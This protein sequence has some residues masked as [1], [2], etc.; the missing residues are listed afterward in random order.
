MLY[1]NEKEIYVAYISKYNS[2]CKKLIILLMIRNEK[3]WHYLR[4]TKLSALLRRITSK[5]N[6]DFCCLNCLHSFR[7]ENKLK[8]Y[9][10]MCKNISGELFSHPPKITY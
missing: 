6:D 7:T 1:E 2:N 3:S 9:E 4:V 10:N 8:S 5:N